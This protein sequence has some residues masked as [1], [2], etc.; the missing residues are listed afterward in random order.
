MNI[1][2]LLHIILLY[3]YDKLRKINIKNIFNNYH[4]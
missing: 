4:M 3:I 2:I 1:L